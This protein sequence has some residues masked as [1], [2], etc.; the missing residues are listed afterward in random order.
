MSFSSDDALSDYDE[1]TLYEDLDLCNGNVFP[2]K[3]PP[4][5]DKD[6]FENDCQSKS[7]TSVTNWT[8]SES[9]FS[10]GRNQVRR[11]TLRRV[12]CSK[13][14]HRK[15]TQLTNDT[16]E[17]CDR[18]LDLK[19]ALNSY[20]KSLN[21][22]S[23]AKTNTFDNLEKA[24]PSETTPNQIALRITKKTC[25]LKSLQENCDITE[26]SNRAKSSCQ[27]PSNI[28]VCCIHT[29]QPWTKRSRSDD[30]DMFYKSHLIKNKINK[31]DTNNEQCRANYYGANI[32]NY[33]KAAM[34]IVSENKDDERRITEN[35]NEINKTANTGI[36]VNNETHNDGNCLQQND[37]FNFASQSELE[38][39]PST[40]KADEPLSRSRKKKVEHNLHK[41][42]QCFKQFKTKKGMKSH[43]A[44]HTGKTTF[45][46]NECDKLFTSR[47]VLKYH[48]ASKHL[49]ELNNTCEI[50]NKSY[51]HPRALKIH[52]IRTHNNLRYKEEISLGYTL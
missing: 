33:D 35:D 46:C 13:T 34:C 21:N 7:S 8:I 10:T 37:R 52:I 32:S 49:T 30:N 50:C 43:Y 23:S 14:S 48:K 25:G 38:P 27:I 18:V 16:E 1:M 2:S 22:F 39:F 3:I 9:L 17:L 29:E 44:T 6:N 4:N 42:D 11:K 12:L 28:S 20:N 40:Q 47:A 51:N 36:R 5:P 24:I 19:E 15:A 45:N 41:C 31:K 26:A